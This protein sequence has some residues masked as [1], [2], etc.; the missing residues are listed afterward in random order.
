MWNLEN[1][2][3]E[4]NCKEEIKTQMQRTNVWL[5]V[6]GGRGGWDELGDWDWHTQT[7]MYK[8]DN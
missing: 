5:P 6:G 3:D 8:I 4:L 2:S 1:D 7:T